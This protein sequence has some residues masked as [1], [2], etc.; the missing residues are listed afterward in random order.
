MRP[1]E[2]QCKAKSPPCFRIRFELE[3]R[4]VMGLGLDVGGKPGL[5]KKFLTPSHGHLVS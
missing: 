5:R 4:A 1:Q 2:S 3:A